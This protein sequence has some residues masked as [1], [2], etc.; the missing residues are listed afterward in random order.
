MRVKLSHIPE[1]QM[2]RSSLT[3]APRRATN[4]SVPAHLPDAARGAEVSLLTALDEL[5]AAKRNQWPE[6]NMDAIRAYN[7]HVGNYGTF[8]DDVRKF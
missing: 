6:A 8:S 7:E 2:S 4:V 1:S 5:V 3:P